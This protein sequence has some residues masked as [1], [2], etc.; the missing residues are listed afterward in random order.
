M[1]CVLP[2]YTLAQTSPI[3]K[4]KKVKLT[5]R[6]VV[7]LPEDFR[8]MTDDEIVRRFFVSRKPLVSYTSGDSNADFVLN[9]T[10]TPGRQQDLPLLK[11]FFKS[12]IQ[13]V[14]TKVEFTQDTL[15]KINDRDFVVLEFSA[16]LREEDPNSA[17]KGVTREYSYMAY[18]VMLGKVHVFAFNCPY[19]AKRTWQPIARSIMNSIKIA[20][21]RE[22]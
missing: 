19:L 1:T 15:T 21:T 22:K 2:L 7:S 11:S 17:H 6:V 16:E 9:Q 12:G 10:T 4:Y 3:P 8:P 18:T 5:D 13:A 20:N 14:Y